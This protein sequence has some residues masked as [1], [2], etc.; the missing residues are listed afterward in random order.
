MRDGYTSFCAT[1]AHL[2]A[3]YYLALMAAVSLD[4][5]DPEEALRLIEEGR[6]TAQRTGERWQDTELTRLHAA[7][8]K[9]KRSTGV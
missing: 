9:R 2:R 6:A 8:T 1:G 7:A 3:P 4:A 5:D